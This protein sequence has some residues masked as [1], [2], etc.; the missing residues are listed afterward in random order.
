MTYAQ[1]N[2]VGKIA[3]AETKSAHPYETLIDFI[4]TD[5]QPNKNNQAIP[6]AE[7][8][9]II[10]SAINMP[11]KIHLQQ[12]GH[13]NAVPVGPIRSAWLGKDGE[14]DVIYAQASIWNREFPEVD[15]FI[16]T[17]YA[18]E[19]PIGTSWEIGY[20]NSEQISGVEWLHD[21]V[22]AATAIVEN[23]AYG[24]MRTRVL[25]VAEQLT[26]EEE[27]NK[28]LELQEQ[29]NRMGEMLRNAYAQ[30][31]EIE[32]S[33]VATPANLEEFTEK[34]N[35]LLSEIA[36]RAKS[37]GLA[38]AEEVKAEL[39]AKEQSLTEKDT[40]IAEL[41]ASVDNL[42]K[43][44]VFAERKYTLASVFTA[45]ELHERKEQLLA[46]DESAFALYAKDVSRKSAQASDN[47]TPPKVPNIVGNRSTSRID[48]IV[49]A[50]NTS[51]ES[52]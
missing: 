47:G 5:F 48:D 22:F 4:L 39:T 11:V 14:R 32:A 49:S 44:K 18:E 20:G 1:F 2:T 30:T 23:P 46:L 41:T 31:F 43:E 3:N 27:R 24:K 42:T 28:L 15:T 6:V 33:E 52:K 45:E 51:K 13:A 25:S 7:A 35:A 36:N 19:I 40:A 21:L 8:E 16:K 29:L 50:F 26:M 37:A 38:T 10:A 17:A 12:K 9:S 34:F